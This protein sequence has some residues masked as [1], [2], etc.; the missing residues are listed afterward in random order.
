VRGLLS[1]AEALIAL[2]HQRNDVIRRQFV[3]LR[4]RQRSS[5]GDLASGDH[6]ENRGS[7]RDTGDFEEAAAV[8]M[9]V[10]E[11]RWCLMAHD[12]NLL[13]GREA[14]WSIG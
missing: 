1:K 12:Q 2:L 9:I 6:A 5:E 8:Q 7:A 14:S 13:R 3:A 10:P 11:K 4:L